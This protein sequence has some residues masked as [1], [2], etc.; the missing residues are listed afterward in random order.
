ME[1]I[2][3]SVAIA[4][5]STAYAQDRRSLPVN[6]C[7]MLST[8]E[9]KEI[10]AVFAGN[11][12]YPELAWYAREYCVGISE[13]KRRMDIQN[14]DAISAETEPGGPPP[15]PANSIGTISRLIEANEAA[16]FAGL[17]IQHA[18]RYGVVVAFTRDAAKTL[19]KYTKDPLFIPLD[20]PGP[21]QAEL[22]ATQERL[23][24]A[25]QNQGA[26][27][28][29]AGVD[30]QKGR[31]EIEVLGD[32]AAFRAA[33]ARGDVELPPY[34]AI[35][36]PGRIPHAAPPIPQD[37]PV[38]T[39]P[40]Y[41]FRSGGIE[42]AILR[43]GTIIF[44][45]GCLR[46]KGERHSPVIVWPNEAA[47]DLVS[48]PGSIRILNRNSGESIDVGKRVR[49]GGNAT[50]LNNE[51]DIVDAGPACPGPYYLI[52]NF[53]MMDE[54]DELGLKS[55]ANELQ[56][57]QQL[58]PEAAL[59]RAKDEKART[60]RL[61]S[62]RDQLLRD[63]PQSF[64]EVTAWNGRATVKFASLDPAAEAR[65]FIPRDL[66]PFVKAERAPRPLAE[67]KAEKNRLL[68]QFEALGIAGRAYE[69]I[70]RGRLVVQADDLAA[71]SKEALAGKVAF[72]EM[73]QIQSSGALPEGS[74]GG[75]HM[76]AANRVLEG[77]PDWDE[78]R[79]LV[80]A[81]KV[82]GFLVTYREG[83]PDRTPTRGQSLE[84]TR[85]LVALGYT[86][87]DLRALHGEGVFPARA[88]VEQNGRAT[89]A[90]RAMLA[91]EVVVAEAI[92]VVT[93]LLGD[94][95]RSTVRLRIVEGLK[96]DLAAGDEVRVRFVTGPGSDGQ[97]HQS[98]EEP[99]L[100]PGL[101]GTMGTG[102][103]WLLN[104]SEP[105]LDHQA[106]LLGKK[107][108]TDG[109]MFAT[110]YGSWPVDGERVGASYAE[111]APGDLPALR[112]TLKPVDQAYE[113][114]AKKMDRPLMRRRLR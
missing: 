73:A 36:E 75:S 106:R 94:G 45:G 55:R 111:V 81:T 8:A 86:A 13:A 74:Y 21:T 23:M 57:E 25:L 6:A 32:L 79:A 63:A 10:E 72:P 38:R 26:R 35:R 112:S 18:P 93:E 98:N 53:G 46:L 58:S 99:A 29:V 40:R 22:R 107:A 16:T 41:K 27:P 31:V 83:E 47:L 77:V 91:Q 78:M 97:Y 19:V 4:A 33:V 30:I 65:R 89:P 64:A 101:P 17:W 104:L 24:K 9:R 44:E 95:S 1:R 67:L 52:G 87:D 85:F 100:L 68:N 113:R 20:R 48:R 42:L 108:S 59:R 82:P 49:L 43:T 12:T 56:R 14:R 50:E 11:G 76:E 37:N 90:N 39:F 88:Y 84:I 61:L 80:E 96:G 92:E 102:T 71:L 66:Q 110:I 109:R 62:L 69:D 15:P 5:T 7:P 103:R 51:T 70:E 34:V 114:A 3:I 105:L 60:E 2:L 54:Y 28:A